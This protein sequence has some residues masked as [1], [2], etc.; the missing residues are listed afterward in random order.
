M[1]SSGLQKVAVLGG[2]RTPFAR[3]RGTYATDT[4]RALLTAALDGLAARFDLAGER[5]DEVVAGAVVKHSSD[6]N[7]TR[8]CVL[9]SCLDPTTP[10]HDVQ[11]ACATGL[12]AVVTAA[13]KI[14][15]GATES[16]VA[17]GT[18]TMSDVPMALGAGL[19]RA[20]TEA[21][22]SRGVSGRVRA[23]SRLRPRDFAPTVVHPDTRTGHSMGEHVAVSA[24]LWGIGREEQDELTLTSHRRLAAAYRSGFMED[25]IVPYR[26]LTVDEVLRPDTSMEQLARLKPVFGRAEPNA[27]MTAGNSTPLTDG[28]ATVL[29]ANDAWARARGLAP[30]AYLTAFDSAAV[31]YAGQPE[32]PLEGMMMGPAHVVPRLLRRVGLG[33]ED[34]DFIEVHEA[35]AAHVLAV[36]AAWEKAGLAP[37]PRERLNVAG[38]SLAT[39]HPFAATGVRIVSTLAK[40]LAER[41]GRRGLLCLGAAGGL[42]MAAILERPP[43]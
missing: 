15:V 4:N 8:E 42:G 41:D 33:I 1:F 25:L 9:D 14:A 5:V 18:D 3:A 23:L 38:S 22:F 17:G 40:L 28:A 13:A 30:L 24:R 20:L 34:F 6:F 29:L 19:R 39:G 36:L 7:L 35:F 11:Q 2:V 27:T 16:A 31:D 43:S 32:D 12:Q 21:R 10:A 26:G 37:V